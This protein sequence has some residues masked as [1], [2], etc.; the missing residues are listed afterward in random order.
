MGLFPTSRLIALSQ[1][2]IFVIIVGIGAEDFRKMRPGAIFSRCAR[3]CNLCLGE[4]G[5]G[6]RPVAEVDVLESHQTDPQLYAVAIPRTHIPN[7]F[8]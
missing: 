1:L 2:P 7:F 6:R 8:T 5:S 3:V 4:C